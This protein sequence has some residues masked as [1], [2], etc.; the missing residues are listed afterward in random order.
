MAAIGQIT[1]TWVDSY[2]FVQLHS[3]STSKPT[4]II[5]LF[6]LYSSN[7]DEIK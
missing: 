4:N 1:Y 3:Y 5:Y 6:L 7:D 2:I